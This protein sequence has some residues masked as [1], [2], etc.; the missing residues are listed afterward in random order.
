MDCLNQSKNEMSSF[1]GMLKLKQGM[2]HLEEE[3][4]GR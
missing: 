2:N 4:G 3:K 1:C